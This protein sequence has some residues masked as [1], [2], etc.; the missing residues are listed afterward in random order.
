MWALALGACAA[1]PPGVVR[2]PS[3]AIPMS[4]ASVLGA[5]AQASANVGPGLSGFRLLP[6][7]RFA[8]EARTTL[9]ER[10]QQSL[11][12]QYY[13]LRND[14]SGRRILALLRDAAMRGVR[15]R[16][17][18][19]D[20]HT[21]GEDAL[22]LGLA[23]QPNVELRLFNPLPA[24]QGQVACRLIA[25]LPQLGRLHRRMHNKMLIAD[26]AFAI[27]GGRNIGD[28][29]FLRDADTNFLDL[30]LLATGAL[31]VQL[32]SLFDA[33]WNSA[34]AYPIASIARTEL[35]PTQ[36]RADFDRHTAASAPVRDLADT[37]DALGHRPLAIDLAEGRLD[38]AW[39]PAWA[40]AD[41]P[42]KVVDRESKVFP[43]I[44]ATA[45]S[46][47]EELRQQVL[48]ATDEVVATTPYLVPGRE[49]MQTLRQLRGKGVRL[50][51]VTN[52]LAAI[53]EPFA[54]AGYLRY[55]PELLRM[56][57]D[58]Y[59][60]SPGRVA[61]SHRLHLYASSSGRLH[62]KAVVID[63][64]LV[65]VGSMNLDPRSDRHNTEVAVFIESPA[66]AQQLLHLIELVTRDGGY[67]VRLGTSGAA[68]WVDAPPGSGDSATLTEEPE[69]SLL[70][71]FFLRL[72]G[73]WL[74]ED[75][76]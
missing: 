45:A 16:L 61:R 76:L 28:S 63:R 9:L 71:R 40:V 62:A 54:F 19:D 65:F 59:E 46:V 12:L 25:S 72:L 74:P 38:L 27:V 5:A 48:H 52:S 33:Y 4:P 66:L 30:D 60:L 34:Q 26:G 20:L 22:L 50:T 68:E 21:A 56:G 37:R 39:A 24:R 23:S 75:L 7:A 14:D 44:A 53:D 69:T 57:V 55:R 8:L 15:V 11:D 31:V 17:L 18:L 42:R 35:S 49:G 6:T 32:A 3:S 29:Y 2:P 67:R 64:E 13:E 70:Q 51:I 41:D 73:P 47:R 1:L 10:A 58:I 36:L 43:G